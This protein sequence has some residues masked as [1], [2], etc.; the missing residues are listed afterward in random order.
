[1]DAVLAANPGRGTTEVPA[2]AQVLLDEL[3]LWG[4]AAGARAGLDRWYD[5]G[6]D[7]PGIV[8]TPNAPVEDLERTLEAFRPA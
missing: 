6:V 7:M 8:L 3:I 4:D 2:A 5:A 1:V